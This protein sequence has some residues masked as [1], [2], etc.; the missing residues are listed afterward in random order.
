MKTKYI[1]VT[2]AIFCA[3]AVVFGAFGA[4][5]LNN[6]LTSNGKLETYKTA[7]IYHIFHAVSILILS[8]LNTSI[9]IE[10]I[11]LIYWCFVAGLLL[12]S[13]SLYALA[14]SGISKIGIITPFGGVLFILAWLLLTY[15]LL[16][17]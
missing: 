4:H 8:V 7:V 17:K 10:N 14:I 12:F 13:G 15:Q 11:K 5:A 3:L 6:L 2:G 16:K 9:K 1:A